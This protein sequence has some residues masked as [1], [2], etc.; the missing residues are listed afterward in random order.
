MGTVLAG[1][2]FPLAFVEL[3]ALRQD[4]LPAQVSKVGVWTGRPW[5]PLK[6]M[7]S[8]QAPVYIR[9]GSELPVRVD[10]ADVTVQPW[11]YDRVLGAPEGTSEVGCY[12][13]K[14]FSDGEEIPLAP[15]TIA[16]EE[17]WD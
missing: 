17:T 12:M 4:R 7:D 13:D 11:G 16:P 10:T 1:L 3:G 9:N 15:G 8:W 5:K 2:E 14:K 6:E